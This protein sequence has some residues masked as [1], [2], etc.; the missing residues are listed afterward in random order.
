MK[1][2]YIKKER[3]DPNLLWKMQGHSDHSSFSN[4]DLKVN[5][6]NYLQS[7]YTIYPMIKK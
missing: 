1:V 3:Y 2:Q 6:V 7:D 5:L 4:V